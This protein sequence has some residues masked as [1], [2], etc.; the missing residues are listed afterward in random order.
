MAVY[1]FGGCDTEVPDHICDPCAD[2]VEGR[3]DGAAFLAPGFEFT[4]PSSHAEWAAGIANK[5]IRIIPEVT[6]SFDGGTPQTGPGF[7]RQATRTLGY[8]MSSNFRDPNYINNADFWD[9]MRAARGW[10][11]VWKVDT[12][13]HISD[14]AVSV[15]PKNPVTEDLT[16]PLVWDVDVTWQQKGVARPYDAPP[17]V[18]GVCINVAP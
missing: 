13:I 6:G 7:G 16:N 8:D 14:N 9:G 18:F 11:Y 17:N 1:Y 12:Q 10:K 4:N 15:T 5:Q 2:L 3:V